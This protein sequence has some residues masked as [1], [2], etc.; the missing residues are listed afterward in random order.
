MLNVCL[1]FDY[2]LFLGK[3]YASPEEI[4]FKRSQNIADA[5]S[6]YGG[7]GTFFVDVCS[8]RAHRKHGAYDY[9]NAFEQ[10]I[11]AFVRE[12]HDVQ[13]HIHPNWI[14]SRVEDNQIIPGEKGYRLH[15]FGFSQQPMN[16]NTIIRDEI[17]YLQGVCSLADENYK[18][19]AYRAGG[20]ALQP[21]KEVFKALIDN[22][23]LIDSSIVPGMKSDT[24]NAYDY[25]KTPNKLNWWIDPSLGLDIAVEEEKNRIFE[26]PVA[27]ARPRLWEL[28]GKKKAELSLPPSKKLGEYVAL[29]SAITK[30]Q[31]S[32]SKIVHRF[33]DYRYVSLDTRYYKRVLD[34]LAYLYKK[35]KL[36][37]KDGYVCLIGHPKLA[38]NYRVDNIGLLVKAIQ[39][40]SRY[41]IVTMRNI[42]N[43]IHKGE[44]K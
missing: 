44:Q 40:D 8:V 41:S 27:T 36:D 29:P 10:Q 22:G 18:C 30:H 23:I 33:F 37:R 1:T 24:I 7:R 32:I 25:T 3:N 12:G 43:N 17:E 5:I 42:Y 19:I 20:F 26:V 11:K 21:E 34:D 9:A 31:G 13:L 14:F 38:D 35:Y 2:E 6:S 4:L 15:D 16:A 39:N 28:I